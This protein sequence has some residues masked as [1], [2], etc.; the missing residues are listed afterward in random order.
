MSS[1][2]NTTQFTKA[3]TDAVRRHR[4]DGT[5]MLKSGNTNSAIVEFNSALILVEL[6]TIIVACTEADGDK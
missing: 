4:E 2:L 3:I 1:S 6:A 5:E